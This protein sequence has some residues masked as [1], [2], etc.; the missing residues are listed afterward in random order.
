MSA[1]LGATT[2]Y[3]EG[4][5]TYMPPG[6]GPEKWDALSADV[7]A[8]G[9]VVW[10]DLN[11]ATPAS[12]GWKK[13]GVAGAESGPYAV[14]VHAKAAGEVKVEVVYTDFHVSVKAG[15]TIPGGSFV[16]PSAVTAGY[17]D[18]WVAGTDADKLKVGQYERKGKY[19]NSG[20]GNNAVGSAS[21]GEVI[22]IKLL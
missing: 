11:N 5:I 10:G 17:V 12:R 19:S 1:I 8:Q 16:K 13:V 4:L 3:K 20:D 18:A 15:A 14:T 6:L 2:A 22:V 9:L 21:A 7:I